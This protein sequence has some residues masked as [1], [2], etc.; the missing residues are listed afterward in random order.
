MLLHQ[1]SQ[2]QL[3]NCP[4]NLIRFNYQAPLMDIKTMGYKSYNPGS[5]K[6]KPH[7]PVGIWEKLRKGSSWSWTRIYG[8]YS[9]WAKW[10]PPMPGWATSWERGEAFQHRRAS[11]V[12]GETC[13][14]VIGRWRAEERGEATLGSRRDLSCCRR[15]SSGSLG[16]ADGT[17]TT[18][19]GGRAGAGAGF[20]A[21]AQRWRSPWLK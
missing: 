2:I 16:V 11:W 5:I 18:G 17:A 10:Q 20:L 1:Q 3:K 14:N 21:T 12:A 19:E 7:S 13:V 4:A 6:K 8:N 9:L 15:Q